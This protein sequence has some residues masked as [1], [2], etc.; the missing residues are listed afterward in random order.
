MSDIDFLK[1]YIDFLNLAK[2]KFG[3]QALLDIDFNIIFISDW[4]LSC[5]KNTT[6]EQMLGLNFVNDIDRPEHIMKKNM[7]F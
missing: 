5:M 3:H 7:R 1:N 4:A 2:K 6:E